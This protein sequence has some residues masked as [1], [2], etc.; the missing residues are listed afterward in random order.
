MFEIWKG[1]KIQF[2]YVR[3]SVELIFCSPERL[4]N[5]IEIRPQLTIPSS[6]FDNYE[7]VTLYTSDADLRGGTDALV[8]LHLT[9]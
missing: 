9:Q 8:I 4:W 3:T 2:W 6:D 7:T 1:L 5:Q